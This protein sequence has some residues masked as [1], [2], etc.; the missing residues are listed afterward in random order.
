MSAVA[1]L[2]AML[3]MDTSNFKAGAIDATGTLGGLTRELNASGK[4]M[5]A[6]SSVASGAGQVL[7]GNFGSAIFSLMA[8]LKGI[9][10]I[11]AAVV[12]GLAGIGAAAYQIGKAFGMNTKPIDD[13][14]KRLQGKATVELEGTGTAEDIRRP[15][16]ER[17]S[18]AERMASRSEKREIREAQF[19][20]K[21]EGTNL[22]LVRSVLETQLANKQSAM[23]SAPTQEKADKLGD[24][25]DALRDALEDNGRAIEKLADKTKEAESKKLQEIEKTKAAYAASKAESD[26]AF[27]ER[28]GGIGGKGI[29]SDSMAAV[30][31]FVGPQ[32]ADLGV[33]D[34]Q[35]RVQQEAVKYAAEQVKVM[36]EV[37]AAIEAQG[38]T[39][40]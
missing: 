15:R 25:V 1:T 38:G 5:V 19:A 3:M 11:A 28:I 29:R 14:F 36:L 2:K 9:P 10:P 21:D 12:V 31:G 17:E 39:L 37:K 35:M 4:Q 24:Q 32:R 20:T 30:G 40:P 8:K 34:R 6:F 7:Q 33:A 22:Q 18:R 23:I 26:Q 16:R 27:G 13:F